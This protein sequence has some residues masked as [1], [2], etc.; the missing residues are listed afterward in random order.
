MAQRVATPPQIEEQMGTALHIECYRIGN[1]AAILSREDVADAKDASRDYRWHLQLSHSE[2]PPT[3]DEINIAKDLLPDETHFC[4]PFPRS[5]FRP[6]EGLSVHFWEVR[7][8]N[9]TEQW[10]YASVVDRD[11]E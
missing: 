9:L 11:P 10:E 8:K 1:C 7:D 2:R 5:G 4:L 6:K 3:W